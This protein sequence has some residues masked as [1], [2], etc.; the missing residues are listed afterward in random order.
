M[1]DPFALSTLEGRVASEV[2]EHL[3]DHPEL[4]EP[5]WADVTVM[6]VDLRG[7]RGARRHFKEP[8]QVFPNLNAHYF[9]PVIR[10]LLDHGACVDRIID[11]QIY[12]IFG[13]PIRQPPA[14]T[15]AR[16]LA[17]AKRIHEALEGLPDR[18]QE[19]VGVRLHGVACGLAS[20][21]AMVGVVGAAPFRSW[22]LLGELTTLATAV[23]DAAAEGQILVDGATLDALAVTPTPEVEQ[24]VVVVGRRRPVDAYLIR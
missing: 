16:A 22:T 12:A 5:G 23:E 13:A 10:T 17:A 15:A 24:Q 3:R 11:D 21:R 18:L 20:G 19:A 1:K 7:F 14:D 9:E 6:C 2:L 4:L 8:S